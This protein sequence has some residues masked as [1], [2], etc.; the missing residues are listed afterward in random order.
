MKLKLVTFLIATAGILP[1]SAASTINWEFGSLNVSG[2]GALA[3]GNVVYLI[4]STTG[5]AVDLSSLESSLVGLTLTQGSTFGSDLIVLGSGT[6]DIGAFGEAGT[7]NAVASSIDYVG[8]LS[9]GDF[10]GLLWLNQ[11]DGVI[12]SGV[13][14]GVHISSTETMP[15]DPSAVTRSFLEEQFGGTIP[16]GSLTTTNITVVP[17]PSVALLGALGLLGLLRRRS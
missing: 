17:E 11:V 15:S 9:D 10:L 6:P 14:F 5:A 12:G 7:G 8:G 4:A 16:D 1:S 3:D 13:K 2:A